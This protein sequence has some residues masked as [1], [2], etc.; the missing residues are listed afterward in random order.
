M[1]KAILVALVLATLTG[2]PEAKALT[3]NVTSDIHA[4]KTKKRDYSKYTPNNIIY[5]KKWGGAFDKFIS[6]PADVYIALG[7]N[8]NKCNTKYAKKVAAKAGGRVL[9]GF[10]NHDCDKT[11]PYLRGGSKHYV[12][13]YGN[14]RVI[15]LNTEEIY[16]NTDGQNDGGFSSGQ[17]AW[18]KDQLRTEKDVVIAMSK[19][20]YKK[21]IVTKKTTMQPFFD[22]IDGKSNIKH[23][24]A[25][26]YHI[27]NAVK[28]YP[29][30]GAIQWHYV[31]ALT[32]KSQ[33]GAFH[34][35]KL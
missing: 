13:D 7:D 9:F 23:I 24:F 29:D 3:I 8:T 33:F 2:V 31:P 1:K 4:D 28:T 10:G 20:A 22:V 16:H 34:Q 35:I 17:I 21:D 26:D 25:G 30:T 15:V 11:W 5:P 12:Q 32:L 18:L 19:P 27:H 14:V 6:T